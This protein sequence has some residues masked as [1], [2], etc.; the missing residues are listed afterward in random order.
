MDM[1]VG[2]ARQDGES[3]F[4]C[5]CALEALVGQGRAPAQSIVLIKPYR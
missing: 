2:E 4:T 3:L 5:G 1:S